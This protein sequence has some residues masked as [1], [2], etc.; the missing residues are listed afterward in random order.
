M[1]FEVLGLCASELPRVDLVICRDCLVHLPFASIGQAANLRRSGSR[2]LLSS[3][4]NWR[5][6]GP[7]VDIVLGGWRRLNLELAP[8]GWRPE[9]LLFEGCDA[10]GYQDKALALFD[11]ASLPG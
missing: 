10:E 1:R 11:I 9:R 6:Q 7:N 5:E 4:F 2:W 3:H 8:F